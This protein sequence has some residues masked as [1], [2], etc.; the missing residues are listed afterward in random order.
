MDVR[1][2][3][4]RAEINVA[5]DLVVPRLKAKRNILASR[6]FAESRRRLRIL[7]SLCAGETAAPRPR[8]RRWVACDFRTVV[9]RQVEPRR[10]TYF[11]PQLVP[12]SDQ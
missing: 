2:A 12:P 1:R 5:V 10:G 11:P 7:R 9:T 3:R 4:R 6:R 8:R